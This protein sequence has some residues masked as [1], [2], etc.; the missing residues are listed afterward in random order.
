MPL[1]CPAP[2]YKGD[3]IQIKSTI[4]EGLVITE[5]PGKLCATTSYQNIIFQSVFWIGWSD[6]YKFLSLTIEKTDFFL[7]STMTNLDGFMGSI[8][9]FI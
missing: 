5:A 3:D 8:N 2:S 1:S 4:F 7:N 9:I 6:S